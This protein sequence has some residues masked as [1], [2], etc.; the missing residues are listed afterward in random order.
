MT[1]AEKF[2][3]ISEYVRRRYKQESDVWADA[4]IKGEVINAAKASIREEILFEIINELNKIEK[5]D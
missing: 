4:D 1:D 3:H 2:K 5:A